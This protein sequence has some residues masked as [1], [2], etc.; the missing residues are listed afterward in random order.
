MPRTTIMAI[1]HGEKPSVDGTVQGVDPSGAA[2]V[3]ELSVRGWQRAGALVQFFAAED[4]V[5]RAGIQRPDFL[6]A[7]GVTHHVTSVRASSTL[8]PLREL[9]GA[10]ISIQFHKGEEAALASAVA[11]L[12]GTVLVAW[13]HHALCDFAR[14]LVGQDQA[15]PAQWPDDRFDMVWVFQRD[16]GVWRFSQIPQLLLSGDRADPI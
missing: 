12:A 13:E 1:R 7:P 6:F 4:G 9:L 16:G 8:L 3:D 15:V 10:P 2:S 5:R 11:Q 14:F